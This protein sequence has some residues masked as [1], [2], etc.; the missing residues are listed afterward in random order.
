MVDAFEVDP[1]PVLE[2]LKAKALYVHSAEFDL[3]FLHHHYGFD[4]PEKVVDILQLSQ[5]AR[6]GEWREKSNSGWELKRHSLKDSL[7][8][9]LGVTL[10]EKKKFQRGKAWTGDLTDEHLKY[11]AGD[12]AHLKALADELFALIKDRDLTEVWELERRAKP[13]FIDMCIQGIPLDKQ[14][15]DRLLYE[16]EDKLVSLRERADE[17]A[18]PHPEEK[19]WSWNSPLQA[20]EAFSLVG[21]KVP[22]LQRETL[23]KYKHRLAEAVAE[24]RN[25]QSL[26]SRVRTWAAGH[27]RDGRIY[28]Q[29]NPAGAAT[30]RASCTSPN[31][32]SLPKGGDF[33]GCI[34]P[35]EGRVLVKADLSQIELRVLA[36]ITEDEAMLEIFRKGEDLHL[37]TAEVLAGRKVKKGDPERQKA[38]AINF[39][40]SFGMGAKRFKEMAASDYGV[41][42]TLSEARDAKQK[43]LAA[44]PAIGSWHQRESARSE[45]GDFETFTLLG[46]RRV[47]KPDNSGKPSFTERLNAPVQ[48]TAADILKL[49]LARLWEGRSDYPGTFPVLTV[50]DEV[51]IECGEK[52]AQD[53]ARWLS[54]TLRGAVA[55]VLVHPE[56]AGEDVVETSVCNSWGEV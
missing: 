47:V 41:R 33:R 18:P 10:R 22:D 32:Q 51:V 15:W 48:G 6:A 50:H 30:G 16:L 44:Y 28:P 11:A 21:L 23:S 13:L 20:K 39:G 12:V 56:L 24:Y 1:S 36:A 49:A 27:Y 8:R 55:D 42:M 2:T 52:A 34:R 31:V 3:P 19:T 53:T 38:K 26:L 46:R 17:L 25:T 29:W 40:L 43:L 54:E 5:V 7:E 37:N 14:R 45:A 4:P 35:L 9:E